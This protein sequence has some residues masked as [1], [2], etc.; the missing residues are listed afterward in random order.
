MMT[1]MSISEQ[2][3]PI[4]LFEGLA[5]KAKQAQTQKKLKKGMSMILNGLALVCEG[6]SEALDST[7]DK[8]LKTEQSQCSDAEFE[9][10]VNSLE[11]V[12]PLFSEMLKSDIFDAKTTAMLGSFIERM[13]IFVNLER[14]MRDGLA[15][16]AS[17]DL[18][19][20]NRAVT[21]GIKGNF[22]AWSEA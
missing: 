3:L 11:S 4:K 9:G 15:M 14:Q 1:T 10:L 22:F 12:M 17:L 7:I 18:E 8:L 13:N 19:E 2:I 16:P 5:V 21:S 20:V 6:A